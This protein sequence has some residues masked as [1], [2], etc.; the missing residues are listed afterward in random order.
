MDRQ[1]DDRQ[2]GRSRHGRV[3]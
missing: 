3:C 2:T 1:M